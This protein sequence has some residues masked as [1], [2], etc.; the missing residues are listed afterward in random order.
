MKVFAAPLLVLLLVLNG[1]RA[2]SGVAPLAQPEEA[3]SKSQRQQQ[4]WPQMLR[5]TTEWK[6]IVEGSPRGLKRDGAL[7]STPSRGT[8]ENGI[9]SRQVDGDNENNKRDL[10]A[11]RRTAL[12]DNA[13][14]E[15][16]IVGGSDAKEGEFPYFV[17]GKGWYVLEHIC[18][19][20]ASFP[21][22]RWSGVFLT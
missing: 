7:E 20:G 12:R 16:R 18:N 2:A 22:C 3:P 9:W 17:L 6:G 1:A 14:M 5:G 8:A 15:H 13:I 10:H 4:Q 11:S 21:F 19:D